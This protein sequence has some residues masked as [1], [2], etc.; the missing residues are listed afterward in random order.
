VE[1]GGRVCRVVD[2][3][4]I[5][6]EQRFVIH[7]GYEGLAVRIWGRGDKHG[8]LLRRLVSPGTYHGTA[9]AGTKA[10]V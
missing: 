4:V 8:M 3:S 10:T 7:R 1:G 5:V 9:W 2:G 6:C